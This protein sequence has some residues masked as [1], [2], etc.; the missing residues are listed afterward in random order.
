MPYYSDTRILGHAGRDAEPATSQ[1]GNSYCKFSVA[2]SRGKDLPT[3]W[4]NVV[5]FGK[6]AEIAAETVR[7]GC[8]VEVHGQMQSN[9]REEREYWNL[10]AHR[11]YTFDKRKTEQAAQAGEIFDDSD[12]TF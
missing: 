6:T 2:V 4:Y 10:V 7:K 8:L 5:C 9:K 1:N 11:V 3:D 12:I